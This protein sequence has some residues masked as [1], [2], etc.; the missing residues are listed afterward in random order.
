MCLIARTSLLLAVVI[1]TTASCADRKP[2]VVVS[3]SQ[4]APSASAGY[5]LATPN[6]VPPKMIKAPSPSYTAE[7][8]QAKVTGQIELMV[9]IG[10][11]GNP[12][13]ARVTKSL[14]K[15]YGLDEQA[16]FAIGRSVFQPATLDGVPVAVN[17]VS[18]TYSFRIF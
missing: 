8:M 3:Q 15:V 13:R 11:D 17:D 9:R 6:L 5:S 12:E 4:Q 7:A 1:I 10:A 14:D 16:M 18:I 2:P